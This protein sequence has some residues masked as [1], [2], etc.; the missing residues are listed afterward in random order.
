MLNA[1]Q[2]QRQNRRE[3]EYIQGI[4]HEEERNKKQ[5]Y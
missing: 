5:R 1:Q 3:I 4:T 2:Q